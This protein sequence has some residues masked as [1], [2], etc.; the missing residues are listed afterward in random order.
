M[1]SFN[2][3]DA[4]FP[5]DVLNADGP[6]LVDFWAEWCTP[7]KV[8]APMLDDIADE[9]GG[10]VTIA[11]L[12]MDENQDTVM[13]YGVR[14]APTLIMFKKGEPTAIKVGAVPRNNLAS[15]IRDNA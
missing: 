13:K 7:C 15:W 1:A 2:V 10:S 12:N 8:I 14:S 11:K 3:T 9:L 6:V 5:S 4:T